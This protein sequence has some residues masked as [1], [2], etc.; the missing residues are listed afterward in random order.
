MELIRPGAM[1]RLVIEKI[2]A[3]VFGVDDGVAFW[4]VSLKIVEEELPEIGLSV[5]QA[6]VR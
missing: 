2:E 3:T 6:G 1:I 4:T 5:E